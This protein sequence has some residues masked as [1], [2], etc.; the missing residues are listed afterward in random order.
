MNVVEYRPLLTLLALAIAA[1]A[2]TLVAC[3]PGETP[4]ELYDRL[5]KHCEIEAG[6]AGSI[7]KQRQEGK[8]YQLALQQQRLMRQWR[9]E[10]TW[11]WPVLQVEQAFGVPQY[12][13]ES[14]RAEAV[15][16]FQEKWLRYCIEQHSEYRILFNE[17]G[18]A[19]FRGRVIGGLDD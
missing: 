14:A 2:A 11:H 7:M 4:Q 18:D 19:M 17:D 9:P 12:E 5:K 1:T 10:S 6:L 15:A 16:E 8:S 3:G 13:D